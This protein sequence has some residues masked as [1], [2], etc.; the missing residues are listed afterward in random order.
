MVI[1][2]GFK[3]PRLRQIF[4]RKI[5]VCTHRTFPTTSNRTVHFYILLIIAL[6][7]LDIILIITTTFKIGSYSE[8]LPVNITPHS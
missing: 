8:N 3:L 4:A 7:F 2:L 6:L 5:S 1:S